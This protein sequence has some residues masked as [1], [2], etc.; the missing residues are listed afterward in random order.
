MAAANASLGDL[1][2]WTHHV[3]Y[4]IKVAI[5][6]PL[7]FVTLI[8]PFPEVVHEFTPALP[9]T[10]SSQPYLLELITE[11]ISNCLS[12]SI[13]C[14]LLSSTHYLC[15]FL[16]L[17]FFSL[18]FFYMRVILSSSFSVTS[19]ISA[20]YVTPGLMFTYSILTFLCKFHSRIS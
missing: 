1:R 12:P 6:Y 17:K 10:H 9:S 20:P 18:I 4:F 19:H 7:L 5:C 11:I 2:T 14:L 15:L 16:F 8:F 3:L 13:H